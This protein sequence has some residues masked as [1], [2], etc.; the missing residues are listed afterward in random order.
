MAR[1]VGA[2]RFLDDWPHVADEQAMYVGAGASAITG[3]GGLRGSGNE[4]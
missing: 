2:M 3:L 4:P 1:Q